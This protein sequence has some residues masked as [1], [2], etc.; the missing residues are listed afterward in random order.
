M[1]AG[2]HSIGAGGAGGGG[3]GFVGSRTFTN[4]GSTTTFTV[5]LTTLTGGIASAPRTGDLVVA[6]ITGASTGGPTDIPMPSGWEQLS[7]LSGDDTWDTDLYVIY[8]AM[9]ATPDTGFDIVGGLADASHSIA[10]TIWVY[11]GASTATPVFTTA[12][13]SDT[14]LCDPPA[15][16]PTVEGSIVL[17]GGGGSHARGAQTYSSSDFDGFLSVGA[18]STRDA[19]IGVGRFA[20]TSGAF[21]PAEFT[22]S[23]ADALSFSWAALSLVLIPA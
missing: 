6:F 14:V 9:G 11:A 8:K 19:T 21:N 18:N 2:R 16:T 22:F 7:R 12:T 4:A 13:G 17:S 5:P 20:W 1:L 10:V 15:I 23:S 3:L